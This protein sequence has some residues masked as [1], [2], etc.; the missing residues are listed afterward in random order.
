V[1]VFIE[2]GADV[3]PGCSARSTMIFEVKI[4]ADGDLLFSMALRS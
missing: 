1:Q 4:A 3:G 2:T